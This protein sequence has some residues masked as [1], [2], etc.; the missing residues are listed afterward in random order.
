MRVPLPPQRGV[1]G[2]RVT[3]VARALALASASRVFA[4]GWLAVFALEQA[5]GHGGDEVAAVAALGQKDVGAGGEGAV[6]RALRGARGEHDD[7]QAAQGGFAADAGNEL[8]APRRAIDLV[9]LIDNSPSMAPK[10]EKLKAQFPKLIAALKDP[11]DGPLPDLR[12]AIID[13][14]LGTGRCES[15][16]GTVVDVFVPS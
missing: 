12:I 1:V 10:Q 15:R 2:N 3:E 4:R 6:A 11:S 13:S 9:F 16:Q 7:G 8:K 5:G 14:D